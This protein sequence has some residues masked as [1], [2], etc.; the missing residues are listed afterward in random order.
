MFDNVRRGLLK[1]KA[2]LEYIMETSAYPR[3]HEQLKALRQA[4]AEK[5]GFKSVMN[6]PVDEVIFLSML[7]KIMNAKRTLEIGVFTGYSL[8]A[9]ALSLP[10][11]GRVTGIDP[12]KEA[13]EIGLPF[14][15]KA[16][17]EHKIDFIQADAM[18]VLDSMVEKGEVGC[19]D[20]VFVDADKT[21]YKH[22][23]ERLHQLVKI[24]GVIAY[25]N[26]LFMGTPA[27]TEEETPEW[28]RSIREAVIDINKV[29]VSDSRFEVS[30]L[31]VGDGVTLCRRLR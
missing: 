28:S 6:V 27:M 24:G 26:T 15:Q 14:I 30:Q 12:D 21:D 7:L 22:Y 25:D 20:F 31:S 13:Y 8:L 2:L 10:D 16:G 18:P 19:F 9:T 11:D 5:L 23:H 29:L 4:S 1:S 17:V 3:E